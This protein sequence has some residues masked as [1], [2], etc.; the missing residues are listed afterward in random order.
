MTTLTQASPTPQSA[1]PHSLVDGDETAVDPVLSIIVVSYNCR[2][3]T[4]EAIR[5]VYANTRLPFELICV[6]NDSRD[7]TVEAVRR[8]FPQVRVIARSDNLGF[9]GGNNLAAELA[10]GSRLLLLNP[11]TI[12]LDG[13]IDKLW[14]FAE[15]TPEA[16]IWG[17]RTVFEDGTLNITSCWGRMTPWALACRMLGLTWLFPK[18]TL[19]NPEAIGSWQRDSERVVDIVTG[20]FLLI[21]MTL[22]RGLGGFNEDFFMYGE[23]ADLCHRAWA[24]GAR[25]RMTPEAT[26][27][28][29]GGGTEVSAADKLVKVLKGK[30]TLMNAHWPRPMR[31]VGRFM[32]LLLAASR[33]LG[34]RLLKPR[35]TRGRGLDNRTDGWRA[36]FRRRHEWIDGWPLKSKATR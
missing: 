7:G 6:D 5:S 9:A 35:S 13:A 36:A 12:V 28:H 21:D 23:E 34:N 1:S 24:V 4:L 29:H 31:P 22:W 32:F 18:S 10:V 25:P 8:E 15:R 27:I 26:I 3:M 14:A 16:G 33:S 20:C 2:E 30:V 11:D 19:F 17:G